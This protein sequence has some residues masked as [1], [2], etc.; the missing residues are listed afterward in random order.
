MLALALAVGSHDMQH[1]LAAL[2]VASVAPLSTLALCVRSEAGTHS[3]WSTLPEM[4]M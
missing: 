4:N 2:L 1:A 3:G